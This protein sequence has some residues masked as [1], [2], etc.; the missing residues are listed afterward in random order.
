MQIDVE[1]TLNLMSG[2]EFSMRLSPW[3]G[4]IRFGKRGKLSS[5]YIGP[6]EIV[7]RIGPVAYRLALPTELYR[8][9]DVFHV[10]MLRKY[11]P[12]PSHVLESQPVELKENLAYEEKPV[13]I[14]DRKEQVLCSKT[15]S[16]VKVLWRNHAIEEATWKSEEQMHP[17]YP[18]IFRT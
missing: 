18:Q 10:S 9:H 4:V 17:Q 5:R 6:Y 1:E 14:L 11:I 7:E 2:I 16:L 12:D 8:I 15:I 13:Q 3:K